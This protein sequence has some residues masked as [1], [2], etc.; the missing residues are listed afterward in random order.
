MRQGCL[1]LPGPDMGDMWLR[2]F[3]ETPQYLMTQRAAWQAYEDSFLDQEV[4]Q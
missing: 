1:E 3:T 4:A 2:A